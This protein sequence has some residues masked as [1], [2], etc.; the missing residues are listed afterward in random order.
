MSQEQQST[1]HC[2]R[3]P[4]VHSSMRPEQFLVV[5]VA[6]YLRQ[7]KFKALFDMNESSRT[8]G[9]FVKMLEE[10]FAGASKDAA[11]PLNVG[12]EEKAYDE[13]VVLADVEFTSYCAHH[14]APFS[15]TYTFAYIPK[16]TIVGLSKI[17]RMVEILAARPQVQER[18]SQ[19]IVQ[20]FQQTVKPNGCGV[21]MD[22]VHT[23][24]C[25][26]GVR[27]RSNTRT[28]AL[29]GAFK[30]DAATRAEFLAAVGSLK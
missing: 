21:I 29:A 20:T 24:M 11:A 13:M 2:E 16:D 14:L 3:V 19:A 5:A 18:L 4:C 6:K 28:T 8:A 23:C 22:A 7:E 26:R 25:T 12:F 27:K 30:K 17:P 9:R 15:G 1:L 10:W